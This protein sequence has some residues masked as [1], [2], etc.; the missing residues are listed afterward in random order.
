MHLIL[1]K[2]QCILPQLAHLLV[3]MSLA[4]HGINVVTL[5]S[6]AGC[7]MDLLQLTKPTVFAEK[8]YDR[9]GVYIKVYE[10]R[11]KFEWVSCY[12]NCQDHQLIIHSPPRTDSPAAH[13]YIGA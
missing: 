13:A 9:P 3:S 8:V 10:A 11:S 4:A 12:A 2:L 1:L 6:G 5:V 7:C